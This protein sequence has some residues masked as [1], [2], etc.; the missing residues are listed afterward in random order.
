[1]QLSFF[2]PNCENFKVILPYW[3]RS[4]F[5]RLSLRQRWL[6]EKATRTHK[7]PRPWSTSKKIFKINQTRHFTCPS[8]FFSWSVYWKFRLWISYAALLDGKMSGLR[9]RWS[10]CSKIEF[11]RLIGGNCVGGVCTFWQK[12]APWR[13]WRHNHHLDQTAH[14]KKV[15]KTGPVTEPIFSRIFLCLPLKNYLL[16]GW[17]CCPVVI[18]PWNS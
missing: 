4:R 2:G 11:G 13:H 18:K 10:I 14:K 16:N 6:Q 15:Q 3:Y 17:N 7:I 12:G 9:A 8:G 5:A 1:M